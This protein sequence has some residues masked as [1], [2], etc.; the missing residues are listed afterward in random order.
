MNSIKSRKQTS[1][2]KRILFSLIPCLLVFFLLES[3]LRIFPFHKD[4]GRTRPGFVIQ[5]KDLGWRLQPGKTGRLATNELGLRDTAFNQNADKTVLLLG[6]SVSWGDGIASLK[7]LYPCLLEQALSE[8]TGQTY[9]VINSSVPGYSTFQQLRYLQLYGIDFS[10]DMIILQFC[11]NDVVERFSSLAQY[12]GDNVFLGVDTRNLIPGVRGWLIRNSRAFEALT[13]LFM[14][15]ARDQQEYDVRK[16]ASDQL[17]H[18][19]ESAWTLT[20]SEIDDINK[21]AM[22]NHIPLMIVIAPY[23]FQ[24]DQPQRNNQPQKVLL[25]HCSD[26]GIPVVDLLPF[27]VSSH[28]Q[29]KLIPLFHD[30]NHFSIYGHSLTSRVLCKSILRL[31]DERVPNRKKTTTEQ[32]H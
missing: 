25:K 11:L 22:D 5:D 31:F 13:R 23:R 8:N 4:S 14:K 2:P 12:G 7:D 18:E 19:L 1:L 29:N 9:E 6:D 28:R 17:S 24:L 30:A 26:N 27:F 21:I 16:M 32:S 10:P 20:L 3:F 15:L